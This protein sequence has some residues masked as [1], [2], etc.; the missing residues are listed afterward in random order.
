MLIGV[1]VIYNVV[2]VSDVQHSDSVIHIYVC[3]CV[4][5]CVY[6]YMYILFQILFLCRLLQDIKY[7]SQCSHFLIA[8]RTHV[9]S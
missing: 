1:E 4:C 2:L 6:I 9:L 7:S 3:V 5:V 8:L